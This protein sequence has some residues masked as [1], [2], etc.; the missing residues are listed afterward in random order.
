MIPCNRILAGGLTAVAALCIAGA[1][2][3]AEYRGG[4]GLV[5]R[6][7]SAGH[8]QHRSDHKFNRH[9]WFRK[10]HHGRRDRHGVVAGFAGPTIIYG[11]DGNGSPDVVD[12]S[13]TIECYSFNPACGQPTSTFGL[14]E[15]DNRGRPVSQHFESSQPYAPPAF[16]RIP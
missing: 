16:I 15:Y 5:A 11:I 12:R 7:H 13:T 8:W 4:R 1:L 10:R 2:E 9:A 6:G 3:A 14:I